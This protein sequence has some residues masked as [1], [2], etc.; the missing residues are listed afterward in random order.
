M[1]SA[2]YGVGVHDF[3]AIRCRCLTCWPGYRLGSCFSACAFK[4]RDLCRGFRTSCRLI[5]VIFDL[6]ESQGN[7]R[8]AQA[9]EV[10]VWGLSFCSQ[11]SCSCATS[12]KPVHSNP[13]IEPKP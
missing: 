6:K 10:L 12:L 8:R 7:A 5:S 2:G 4:P 3:G 11:P 13:P 1:S 9:S